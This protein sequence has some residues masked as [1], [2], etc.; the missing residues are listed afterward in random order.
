M[1]TP[2]GPI[3]PPPP[4]ITD[5][6]IIDGVRI[7]EI[8]IVLDNNNSSGRPQTGKVSTAQNRLKKKLQTET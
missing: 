2:D 1:V 4:P 7:K 8:F 6:A 3:R 5:V